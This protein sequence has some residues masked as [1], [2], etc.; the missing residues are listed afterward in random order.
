MQEVV[1]NLS[2]AQS[3][4][5]IPRAMRL[6]SRRKLL[7]R[8]AGDGRNIGIC[9]SLAYNF[10]L[11]DQ[12]CGAALLMKFFPNSKLDISVLKNVIETG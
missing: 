7:V 8:E 12:R 5:I 11:T 2:V 6:L 4:K 3:A 1:A 9:C 10:L